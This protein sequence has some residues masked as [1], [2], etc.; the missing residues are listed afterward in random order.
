MEVVKLTE[1]EIIP[2]VL[3]EYFYPVYV[4]LHPSQNPIAQKQ[5]RIPPLAS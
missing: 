2:M 4:I 3:K 1:Q 5:L